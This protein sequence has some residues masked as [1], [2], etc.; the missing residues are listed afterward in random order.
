MKLKL[1]PYREQVGEWP[2]TGRHI[3]AQFDAETIVV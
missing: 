1:A 2:A 3:L